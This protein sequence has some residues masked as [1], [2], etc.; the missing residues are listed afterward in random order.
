MAR[1]NGALELFSLLCASLVA[2]IA[3]THPHLSPSLSLARAL[4]PSSFVGICAQRV[5][6]VRELIRGC[7]SCLFWEKNFE[8]FPG[9]RWCISNRV[10]RKWTR[11]AGL[12]CRGSS[13]TFSLVCPCASPLNPDKELNLSLAGRTCKLFCNKGTVVFKIATNAEMFALKIEGACTVS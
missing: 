2:S 1:R 7:F 13:H 5:Q 12:G 9:V 11:G 3:R 4:L 6:S 10:P 8:C